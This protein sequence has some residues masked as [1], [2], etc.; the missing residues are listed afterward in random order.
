MRDCDL[1][2][3]T[4]EFQQKALQNARSDGKTRLYVR[5]ADGGHMLRV[6]AVGENAGCGGGLS[7]AAADVLLEELSGRMGA[8]EVH[9]VSRAE[10]AEEPFAPNRPVKI[11]A[12]FLLSFALFSLIALLTPRRKKR[13]R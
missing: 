9:L 3:N 5:Q 10:T 1:L 6:E 13:A 2:I 4:P 8:G 12:A 11:A 7:N